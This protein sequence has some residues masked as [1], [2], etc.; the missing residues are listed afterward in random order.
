MHFQTTVINVWKKAPEASD[1]EKWSNAIFID[2]FIYILT[3]LLLFATCHNLKRSDFILFFCFRSFAFTSHVTRKGHRFYYVYTCCCWFLCRRRKFVSLAESTFTWIIYCS[4]RKMTLKKKV[5][6][7]LWRSEFISRVCS[8]CWSFDI[9]T[10]LS[11]EMNW[12]L[13]K[14]QNCRFDNHVCR[15]SS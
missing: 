9:F 4:L 3:S 14:F 12:R 11:K 15:L 13:I 1:I 8:F 5:F 7:K 2:S 6:V 10:S